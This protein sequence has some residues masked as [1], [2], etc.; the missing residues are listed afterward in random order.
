LSPH[1]LLQTSYSANTLKVLP[2]PNPLD[3]TTIAAGIGG[4]VIFGEDAG[5][6]SGRSVASAGDINGDGFADL[7]IGAYRG[8]AAGNAKNYAG[9]SYVIFGK[10]SFWAAVD[11]AT[12]ASG[13]GGFVIHGQDSGD[14]SGRSVASAGD[15]NGDGFGDLI[16]GAFGGD[17]AGNAKPNAGDSYV[18]FGKASGFG[19]AVDLGTVAAGAGGFV[20]HGQDVGDQSGFS[21]ASAG[22]INGDGFGDLIIGAYGGDAAGNSKAVAGDS[23]VIFGKA[24]SFGAAVDLATIAAGTGGF[25]I[26]GQ[27][28]SDASGFSVASGGDIN[29]DGFSDLIIGARNGDAAGNAK[30]NAGDSYVIFGKASGF[31]S[32]IDLASVAAG[33]GGFVIHGHDAGDFSGWSVASAGDVNGDGFGD[34]LIG[35]YRGDAA[36]NAKGSAGDS[37]VVFGKASSFGAAIDLATIAAGVGG[38]VIYGQDAGD[39][40]GMSVASGGDINGDG[41]GDLIIG[42]PGADAAGNAKLAAGGTYVIFGKSPNPPTVTANQIFNAEGS[43]VEAAGRIRV[44]ADFSKAAYALQPW[45]VVGGNRV[46]NDDSPFSV[47]AYEALLGQGWVP[48]NL[49][50]SPTLTGTSTISGTGLTVTNSVAMS[51]GYFFNGNAAAL[52]ARSADAL[53]ISFRGTNDNGEA[54]S[55]DS[56]NAIHP[57]KDQWLHMR[58]HYA[59]LQPLLTAVDQ[60]V[61][62]SANGITS[63]YVT[64]HSLGGSMVIQYMGTHAG[65][66]YSAVTFAAAGFVDNGPQGGAYYPDRTRVTHIEINDDPVPDSGLHGGRTIHFEGDQDAQGLL[67]LYLAENHPMDYYRQI[68]KS[69]DSDSW[70]TILA[71]PGDPEVYIGAKIM[72]TGFIVDGQWSGTNDVANSGN[73]TLTDPLGADYNVYYGGRG[74][75]VLTGGSDNEVFLGGA[76]NDTI[77]AGFG[78]DTVYGGDGD[79]FIN[80]GFNGDSLSGGAGN[81]FIGGG[82]GKDTLDG[83]AGNDTL[84]GG[85]GADTLT[86]GAGNDRF[87]FLHALDGVVNVDTLLDFQSGQDLFELSAA[88][89]TVFSGQ[90]GSTVSTSA[91]LTYN[92]ATGVLVYDADGVGPAVPLTFAILGLVGHP[93]LLGNDFLIVA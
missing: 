60:Y 34:L 23:Y 57:D 4:F 51:K 19:A 39:N 68:T 26:H 33:T 85:F 22:D 67:Q 30:S 31:E 28:A 64:G 52:V 74:M 79:D 63:V 83:G 54:N 91:N 18:I 73:D 12:I 72:A 1:H 25:V 38:F 49:A 66:G 55:S 14:E 71:Q 24:S 13:A 5:D 2:M 53:V 84:R 90:I 58:D 45:E 16:I 88:I 41:F 6:A 35:A 11:L 82:N 44:L 37:Y 93:A 77:V 59:L 47:T 36:G 65:A 56:A 92:N 78:F 15:I 50:P 27:D 80:G 89:F 87:Q 42:A 81:D 70:T 48:V 69:V 17:A 9:D 40:S 3:L 43:G 29:G 20:I 8:D 7:I 61:A 62:N 32:A 21:V 76:G 86:G 46:I 10:A 75:D